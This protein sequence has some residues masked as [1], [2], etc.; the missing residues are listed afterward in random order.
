LPAYY[1]PVLQQYRSPSGEFAQDA[2]ALQRLEYR[3]WL[4]SYPY[5]ITEIKVVDGGSGY[6]TAP[7]VTITG[8]TLTNDAVAVAR[9]TGGVVTRISLLYTRYK[10]CYATYYHY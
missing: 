10:L 9:V 2:T 5:S 8:S 4:L 6:T 1:D 7:N 3:D